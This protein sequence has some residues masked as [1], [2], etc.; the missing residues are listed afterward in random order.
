MAVKM[1]RPDDE[2]VS[3]KKEGRK[4]A[5][6]HPISDLWQKDFAEHYKS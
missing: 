3:K 2:A 1:S 4:E 5:S 6:A